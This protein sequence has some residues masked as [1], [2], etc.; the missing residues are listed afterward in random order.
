MQVALRVA[1]P[2]AGIGIVL[3]VSR[4]LKGAQEYVSPSVFTVHDLGWLIPGRHAV[5]TIA[6]AYDVLA[7]GLLFLASVVSVAGLGYWIG[8]RFGAETDLST[9]VVGFTV[10]GLLGIA[11]GRLLA[12]GVLSV[13]EVRGHWAVVWSRFPSPA[14]VLEFV[15]FAVA[16]VALAR[17]DSG[18]R[19]ADLRERPSAVGEWP[20]LLPVLLIGTEVALKLA[21]V[22]WLL[23]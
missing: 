11:A 6:V 4:Y 23:V 5:G 1:L 13:L 14:R 22:L 12:G 21:V 16:G 8:R 2:S 20:P 19:W 7:G 15:L 10:G 18:S 3:G 17:S 9:M